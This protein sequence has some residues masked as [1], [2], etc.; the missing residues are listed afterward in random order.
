M[1]MVEGSMSTTKNDD[2]IIDIKRLLNEVRRKNNAGHQQFSIYRVPAHIRK[3]NECY[4]EPRWV[5]IGPYHCKKE[6][7]CAMDARKHIYFN[8]FINRK[9]DIWLDGIREIRNLEADIRACYFES[10]SLQE[11]DQFVK[12]MLFDSC[13]IIQLFF[14]WC[15]KKPDAACN[16]GWGLPLLIGDLLM[17]ENQ[18][19]F[20]VLDIMFNLYTFGCV[21]PPAEDKQPSFITLAADTLHELLKKCDP[22][23]FFK[24]KKLNQNN[25]IPRLIPSAIELK[26]FG[27]TLKKEKFKSYLDV[28][29]KDGILEVPCIMIEECNRSM[30]L[31]LIASEQC[32]DVHVGLEEKP[33]SSYAVF[34][35]C[36]MNISSDVIVLERAGILE[37]GAKFFRQLRDC[38]HID[39]DNHYLKQVFV[40]VIDYCQAF[41]PKHRA[42]LR[43]GYFNSPW[44]IFSLM[45]AVLLASGLNRPIELCGECFAI[46]GLVYTLMDLSKLEQNLQPIF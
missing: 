32:I 5:S 46:S 17:L 34:M 43:H 26:E 7:L 27:V 45:C 13:F 23:G 12:M 16:P 2:L 35:A 30:F 18:I 20:F 41:W 29:F 21:D 8:E 1:A 33:L 4:Y 24:S 39:F 28:S 25:R 11:G 36:V 40:E 44:T 37:E 38:A 9:D 15:S 6:H 19:P 14:N 3:N 10:V 22:R 42:E 31:N